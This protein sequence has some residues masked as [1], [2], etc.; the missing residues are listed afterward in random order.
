[1]TRNVFKSRTF[2]QHYMPAAEISL[3]KICFCMKTTLVKPF[4]PKPLDHY[5]DNQRGDFSHEE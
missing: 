3:N 5:L 2:R 1:M 4:Q